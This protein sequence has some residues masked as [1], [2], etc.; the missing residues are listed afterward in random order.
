M[1]EALEKHQQSRFA[2]SSW[3]RISAQ[4]ALLSVPLCKWLFSGAREK[5]VYFF[6]V[7]VRISFNVLFM[8]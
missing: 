6:H 4:S 5:N 7:R 3:L 1:S 8:T 2:I